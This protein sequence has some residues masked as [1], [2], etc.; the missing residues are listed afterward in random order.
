MPAA[1][2]AQFDAVVH[3]SLALHPPAH[4]RLHEQVH[5]ALL[6]NPGPDAMFDVVA[7]AGLDD[8]RL[9]ALLVQEVREQEPRWSRTDDADLCA[10]VQWIPVSFCSG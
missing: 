1:A 10:H 5:R 7:A 9:D 4:A 6:E 3:E 8:H 2:E